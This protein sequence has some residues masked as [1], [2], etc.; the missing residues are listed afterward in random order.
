MMK[1]NFRVKLNK[2]R[3]C[4]EMKVFFPLFFCFTSQKS[5]GKKTRSK[6]EFAREKKHSMKLSEHDSLKLDT[7]KD[8]WWKS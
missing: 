8:K 4:N 2:E 6:N 1:I 5:K 3:K 7:L